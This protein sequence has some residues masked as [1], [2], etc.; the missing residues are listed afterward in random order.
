VVFLLAASALAQE[1]QVL[2]E[3]TVSL[4][5]DASFG[6]E[7]L[8]RGS[9]R[10]AL[11]DISGEKWFVI[12]KG[13]QEVA[14]DVAIELPASELPTQ[15]LQAEVLKGEEYYRVRVRQGDSVY[16]IHFLLRG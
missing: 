12:S 7:T 1:G 2:L 5:R 14:R 16:L 8:G 15:G 10:I 9:Y 13:G 4:P 3:R 11:T 6:D